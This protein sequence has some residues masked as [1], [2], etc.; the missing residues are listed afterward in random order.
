MR[1]SMCV[2]NWNIIGGTR[3]RIVFRIPVGDKLNDEEVQ[4][5]VNKMNERFKKYELFGD[6]IYLPVKTNKNHGTE[7]RNT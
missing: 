6:D 1:I 2:N 5:Y 4:E 7:M 3:E